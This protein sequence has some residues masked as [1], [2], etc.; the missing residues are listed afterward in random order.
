MNTGTAAWTDAK[1][2]CVGKKEICPQLQPTLWTHTGSF[3]EGR[4][5]RLMVAASG[6]RV[7]QNRFSG[8]VLV[9]VTSWLS[10][11]SGAHP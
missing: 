7:I 8:I 5:E 2:V 6:V 9:D 1:E 4:S 11:H 10:L 3:Q